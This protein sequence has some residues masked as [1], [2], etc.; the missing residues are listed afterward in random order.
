ISYENINRANALIEK[1]YELIS[2][3]I[4]NQQLAERVKAEA[5]F[6]RAFY[7][8]N[9]VRYFD[10]VPFTTKRTES[11][12]DLPCNENGKR[13]VL[14]LI[15]SDLSEVDNVLQNNYPAND[16][17]RATKWAAYTLLMKAYLLD[18]KWNEAR[19]TAETIINESGISLFEDFAHNF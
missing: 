5:I 12:K 8:F 19:T 13:K 9:L 15:E 17:G 1:A 2:A 4:P 18:E 7:Y 16:L 10:D 11:D 6:L 3:G 14:D